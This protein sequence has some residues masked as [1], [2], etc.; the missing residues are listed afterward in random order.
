MHHEDFFKGIGKKMPY[1]TPESFFKD[2]EEQTLTLIRHEPTAR[3]I[4]TAHKINM[5]V[6]LTTAAAVIVALF[7]LGITVL[8]KNG[9]DYESIE[10]AFDSLPATDQ[11]YIIE[12]YQ[13][14]YFINQ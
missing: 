2:F 9:N 1:S 10:L 12:T 6:R 14:D 7:T 4:Y 3:A 8:D 13:N 11:E 5:V